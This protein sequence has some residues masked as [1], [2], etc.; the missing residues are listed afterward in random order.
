MNRAWFYTNVPDVKAPKAANIYE[1]R[2]L[3]MPEVRDGMILVQKVMIAVAPMARTYLKIPGFDPGCEE[4]GLTLTELGNPGMCES[5]GV[6]V[7]SKSKKYKLGT[8][9]YLPFHPLMEFSA[10]CD[11]G[12]DSKTGPPIKVHDSLRSEDMMSALSPGAGVTAYCAIN[13]N[14]A[15][16]VDD[17]F[18]AGGLV[19]CFIGLFKKRQQ[20]TVLVT[21]AAGAVGVIAGQLYKSKGCKV[22]GVTST[23]EKADRLLDYGFDATIAYKTEDMDARLKELSPEGI[24]VFMDNVGAEQLDIGTRHM[25]VCGKI[26]SIGAMSEVDNFAGQVKGYKEYLRVPARELTFSGFLMY[27]HMKRIP[28]SIMAMV[29]KVRSG[30]VKSAETVVDGSFE[31]W[32]QAV[33]G[34]YGG[35]TFGR[36][37][38][39]MAENSGSA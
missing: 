4:L 31:S 3:P 34:L 39:N 6:V 32:A 2:S 26:V 23:R 1:L 8:R 36:L 28:G 11:D 20:K 18:C 30:T 24:D 27:N 14:I 19:S 33:D 37:I 5:V 10:H 9:I 7:E 13:Y 21:S 12:S 22:I 38:L 17:A 16:R 35:A 29:M 15:G 25:K